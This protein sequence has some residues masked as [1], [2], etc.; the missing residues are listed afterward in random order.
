MGFMVGE[1]EM[2]NGSDLCL[3]R[4]RDRGMSKERGVRKGE[5]RES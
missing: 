5:V 2:F 1:R 3:E 4:E